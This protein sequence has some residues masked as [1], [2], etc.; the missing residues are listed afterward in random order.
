MNLSDLFVGLRLPRASE[1]DLLNVAQ[2]SANLSIHNLIDD[3][4]SLFESHGAHMPRAIDTLP[5]LG[6]C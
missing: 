3:R 4:E 2:I 1:D 5:D 6:M